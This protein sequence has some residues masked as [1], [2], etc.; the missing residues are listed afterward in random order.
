M[1]GMES[2]LRRLLDSGE[3]RKCLVRENRSVGKH[4]GGGS[5][6][7]SSDTTAFVASVMGAILFCH[8]CSTEGVRPE[9]A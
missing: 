7:G 5:C 1:V 9:K 2:N 3:L 8:A 6:P 4:G